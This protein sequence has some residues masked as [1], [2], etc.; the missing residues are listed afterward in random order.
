MRF[1]TKNAKMVTKYAKAVMAVNLGLTQ[2]KLFRG[3]TRNAFLCS[4]P[5]D[6]SMCA[7][8]HTPITAKEIADL[9]LTN[10]EDT[11][12]R[13]NEPRRAGSEK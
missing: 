2:G 10:E 9:L 4:S 13:G 11:K 8:T 7:K 1:L 5:K 3:R 6:F 12:E